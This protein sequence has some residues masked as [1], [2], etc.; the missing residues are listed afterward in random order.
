MYSFCV[1]DISHAAKLSSF[2]RSQFLDTSLCTSI[3]I[4]SIDKP[5]SIGIVG[6]LTDDSCDLTCK[7]KRDY[8]C[9]PSLQRVQLEWID[10][11]LVGSFLRPTL[12][13]KTEKAMLSL[14]TGLCF[15]V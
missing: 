8:G 12:R 4:A 5:A 7:V 11:L 6:F 9:F 13:S 14:F 3:R 10:Q 2:D 1:L 15:K